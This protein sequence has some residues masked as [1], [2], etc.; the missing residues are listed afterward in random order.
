MINTRRLSVAAVTVTYLQLMLGGVVRISGSGMGCGDNW[1]KCNGSWI[2]P[3][4]QP[5]VMIEWTHRLMALLVVITVGSLLVVAWRSGND[6]RALKVFRSSAT[7]FALVIGVALLGMVTVKLGNTALAT[8]AHWT[9]AMTLLGVLLATAVRTGALGADAA[10]SQGGTHRS[11]RSIG[12]GAAMAF[13]AVVLGALVAKT[14][15]AAAACPSF[16]L[17]G[18]TPAGIEPGAAHLQI[19]H[20]VLAYVLFFHVLAITSA[21]RRRAGESG[22]VKRALV[23]AA[24]LVILQVILGASMIL[25]TMPVALRIAHEAT[26]VAVWMTL[27]LAAYLARTAALAKS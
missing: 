18:T 4:T 19:T 14:A 26:G 13:A 5:T 8:V 11:A 21:V 25:T 9:L 22:A 10:L 23:V 27:F 16:P 2:P 1:P 7:A 12:A 15:G 6:A 3:F 24:A 20:R 17:C